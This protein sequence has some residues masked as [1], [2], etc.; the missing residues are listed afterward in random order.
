MFSAKLKGIVYAAIA[1]KLKFELNLVQLLVNLVNSESSKFLHLVTVVGKFKYQ[2][3]GTTAILNYHKVATAAW[4]VQSYPVWWS[5]S[6]DTGEALDLP[7][8]IIR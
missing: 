1:A 8:R 3:A 4:M 6:F 2:L 5:I 7:L